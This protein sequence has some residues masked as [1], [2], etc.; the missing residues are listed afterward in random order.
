MKFGER[1]FG[2]EHS[3]G[4]VR[5]HE[6]VCRAAQN[7]RVQIFDFV[8]A[9]GVWVNAF[10]L[11]GG[12]ASGQL[13]FFFSETG[14]SSDGYYERTQDTARQPRDRSYRIV[15]HSDRE[16]ATDVAAR[17]ESRQSSRSERRGARRGGRRRRPREDRSPV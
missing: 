1:N 6:R 15:A 14:G 8:D 13:Y 9:L 5:N 3:Q 12:K 17:T 16:T 4:G 11:D 2:T 10:A 7:R